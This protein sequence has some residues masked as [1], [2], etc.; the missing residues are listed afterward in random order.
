MNKNLLTLLFLFGFS[1]LLF[2]QDKSTFKR[3][4]SDEL[5]LEQLE[6]SIDYRRLFQ[7]NTAQWRL[8]SPPKAKR[9]NND[10]V[11][12]TVVFHDLLGGNTTPLSS[13]ENG[14]GYIVEGINHIY[15]GTAG[16][17]D[18]GIRFCLARINVAGAAVPPTRQLTASLTTLVPS[19]SIQKQQ[20]ANTGNSVNAFPSKKY[21][22]IYV[23]DS[24]ANV[25]GFASMPS[26]HGS[27]TDGIFIQRSFLRND[28]EFTDH[29]KVLA[30]ELGH[31]LG[32]FHTFGICDPETIGSLTQGG[33]NP[34]S[35]DNSDPLYNGDMVADTPPCML[36]IDNYTCNPSTWPD[37]CAPGD[38]PDLKNNYMD[39]G[40]QAC[41]DSFTQGQVDRMHFMIDSEFGVRNSLLETQAC[42][43][44][45]SFSGCTA[46]ITPS[47]NNLNLI[48]SADN[49]ITQITATTIPSYTF[50]VTFTGFGCTPP[51]LLLTWTLIEKSGGTII[52]SSTATNY[53]LPTTLPVGYYEIRVQAVQSDNPLCLKDIKYLFSVVPPSIATCPVVFPTTNGNWANAERTA[54]TGGWTRDNTAG[55]PYTFGNTSVIIPSTTASDAFG[56]NDYA[57]DTNFTGISGPANLDIMRVGHRLNPSEGQ[58]APPGNAQYVTL[59]FHPTPQNCKFKLHYIGYVELLQP[60]AIQYVNFNLHT[61]N[62]GAAFGI[63]S[64]YDYHSP[65]N[66]NPVGINRSGMDKDG[67]LGLNSQNIMANVSSF[68]GINDMVSAKHNSLPSHF[69]AFGSG[70]RM[71][72]WR[73]QILD[74][75]EF[76]NLDV[77]G[78]QTEITLTFFAHSNVAVNAQLSAYAY[79]AIECAGGG[80]PEPY[81]L[82]MANQ[83]ESC[84]GCARINF[85]HPKYFITNIQNG[86]TFGTSSINGM[87]RIN[88]YEFNPVSG[89]YDILAITQANVSN[90]NYGLTICLGPN[91][92]PFKDFRAEI[93]TLHGK[94]SDMVRVYNHFQDSYESCG[95][96]GEALSPTTVLV[97]CNTALPLLELTDSCTFSRYEWKRTGTTEVL[98]TEKDYQVKED[99]LWNSC[100]VTFTRT[101]FYSNPWCSIDLYDFSESFTV[102]NP[103]N[104][105]IG[106][107]ADANNICM[108]DIFTVTLQGIQFLQPDCIPSDLLQSLDQENSVTLQLYNP[109]TQ[110]PIGQ[111]ISFDFQGIPSSVGNGELIFVNED[112]DGLPIFTPSNNNNSFNIGLMTTY[113]MFGCTTKYST[114]HFTILAIKNSAVGGQITRQ[115]LC[116]PIH[117]ISNDPGI[118][119]GAY[120]WQFSTDGGSTW[121]DF[122]DPNLFQEEFSNAD[123]YF[124]NANH[125]G[126]DYPIHIRRLSQGTTECANPVPSNRVLVD[127]GTT[128]VATFSSLPSTLCSE[129]AFPQLPGIDDNGALGSWSPPAIVYNTSNYIFTPNSGSCT[130]TYIY[131]VT[132]AKPGDTTFSFP[133]SLCPSELPFK[134]PSHSLQGVEGVWTPSEVT[135]S[136]SY[137]FHPTEFI[138]CFPDAQLEITVIEGNQP[139]FDDLVLSYCIGQPLV[140]PPVSD[141]NIAGT[142]SP[143]G[144]NTST[145][146]NFPIIFTPNENGNCFT[147]HANLIVSSAAFVPT[148]FDFPTILCPNSTAPVLPS[149]SIEGVPGSW[150]PPTIS[151]TV[152]GSY[153]FTPSAEVCAI[154]TTIN[155]TV[156]ESCGITLNW[157]SEVTCETASSTGFRNEF[158]ADLEGGDCIKVCQG[159]AVTY[160]L[161]G[162]V[163]QIQSTTWAV[164]GGQVLN[165]NNLHITVRWNNLT[166]GALQGSINLVGGG[167]MKIDKCIEVIEVPQANFGLFPHFDSNVLSGCVRTPVYFENL[168]AG[169]GG[170]GTLYYQWDFGD[171]SFSSEFEPLHTYKNRGTY[172]VTLTIFNGCNCSSTIAKE[173]VIE[174]RPILI[175]CNSMACE[176]AVSTYSIPREFEDCRSLVWEVRGGT[177]ISGAHSTEISVLWN[178]MSRNTDGFGY[179]SVHSDGCF[180]SSGGTIKVPVIMHKGTIVGPSEFCPGDQFT[181]KLP[182]WPTTEFNWTVSGASATLFFN[183]QRNEII[184]QANESGTITLQCSYYNTVL[185]CGGSASKTLKVKQS[186]QLEGPEKV[187]QN[188]QTN[189]LILNEDFVQVVTPWRITGPSGFV[190]TGNSNNLSIIF[191]RAGIYTFTSSSSNFCNQNPI[192]IEVIDLPSQPTVIMGQVAEICPGIQLN[193]SSTAP[194]G[195]TTFWTVEGGTIIGSSAGNSVAVNFDPLATVPYRIHTWYE[196]EL[197]KSP[198]LTTEVTPINPI[199]SI[200]GNSSA[201]SSCSSEYSINDISAESYTWSIVPENAGSLLASQNGTLVTVLWNEGNQNSATVKVV[202]K[203]CGL[204]FERTKS[205]TI[206][207]APQATINPVQQG[208]SND[209]FSFNVGVDPSVVISGVTW[210]FGDG[211]QATGI[212]TSHIFQAATTGST[213]YI[214][215]ASIQIGGNCNTTILKTTTVTV[216]PAP[217]IDIT[218]SVIDL[219]E[220]WTTSTGGVMTISLQDGFAAT[221]TIKWYKVASPNDLLL[222]SGPSSFDATTSGVGAYY[223]MVT[224]SFGCTKTTPLVYLTSDCTFSADEPGTC[225]AEE[226]VDANIVVNCGNITASLNAQ[227]NPT[228]VGWSINAPSS[229]YTVIENNTNNYKVKNLPPGQYELNI[230]AVY[231]NDGIS[232]I[233]RK[234]KTFIVPYKPGLKFK[235]ECGPDGYQVTFLDHSVYIAQIAVTHR[236]FSIDGGPWQNAVQGTGGIYQLTVS[237]APGTHSAKM[238]ISHNG[239]SWCETTGTDILGFSL[240]QPPVADFTF[241]SPN[242]ANEAV[243]FTVTNPQ[244]GNTYLWDFG[245]LTYNTQQNPGKTFSGHGTR[246]VTLSVTNSHGC[247]SM[248]SKFVEVQEVSLL[249]NIIPDPAI[250]CAGNQKV[251]NYEPGLLQVMPASFEWHH[252]EPG[253]VP[254]AVT[255]VPTLTVSV[256]GRYF[257]YVT[258]ANGCRKYDNGST[259]VEFAPIPDPPYISG[260]PRVCSESPVILRVPPVAGLQY[261]WYRNGIAMGGWSTENVLEDYPGDGEFIYGVIARVSPT[262]GMFCESSLSTFQVTVDTIGPIEVVTTVNSCSPYEVTLNIAAPQAGVVYRWSNGTVGTQATMRHDG[263]VGVIASLNDCKSVWESDLPVDL[264]KL[265]WIFPQGC[266]DIC[267]RKSTVNLLG[268]Y[269][270][271]SSWQWIQDGAV[272]SSGTGEML[273]LAVSG[274][275]HT[276]EMALAT[277]H[278]S[279]SRGTAAFTQQKCGNCK[280]GVTVLDTYS[281]PVDGQCRFVLKLGLTNPESVPEWISVQVAG[282]EGYLV[283]ST[284]QAN[285][286]YSEYTVFFYPLNG[287]GGGNVTISFGYMDVKGELCLTEIA[288][289]FPSCAEARPPAGSN[290]LISEP[291][292]LWVAPNPAAEETTAYYSFADKGGEKYVEVADMLGRILISLQVVHPNGHL[293]LDFSRYAAGNYIIL[294]RQ[295]NTNVAQAKFILKKN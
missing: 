212:S 277:E 179:V 32:L 2:S 144:V 273:P 24:I 9:K 205:V 237:L 94:F 71:M 197:C 49:V 152:S 267:D 46:S 291:N 285:P 191:P 39:Y 171:G 69:S 137:V 293:P 181:F 246:V 194:S 136:G 26:N 115:G 161:S 67:T 238:R 244:P 106:F 248:I 65:L 170:N 176:G 48:I 123:I 55:F 114:P 104:Y 135:A 264:N 98:G 250:D 229:S 72:Q 62:A 28:S 234:K 141:N 162:S 254:F 153:I 1:L 84:S 165:Q 178:D 78:V 252:N 7:E 13:P 45:P 3:C 125:P 116:P 40:F 128:L 130:E 37:T 76:V 19:N 168:S 90:G 158:F 159:S 227:G 50:S 124:P 175:L 10:P 182:Q 231:I 167:Q 269:G 150:S 70:S 288:V 8:W 290:T 92:G 25:A 139:Q 211:T 22:N 268:P 202:A 266:Y 97:D 278:C 110:L 118:T 220:F 255:T 222:S 111:P 148:T 99:D 21:I 129:G 258:D 233:A 187:C 83:Q 57:T 30:H 219:C 204:N 113:K 225:Y 262:N 61:F 33:Y 44:C 58:F 60:T 163:S 117:V 134:L 85:T 101:T 143:A 20:L 149:E 270:L 217:I 281:S 201:F 208:C 203:R 294:L 140:L 63:L 245:D 59:K 17:I 180:C 105:Q 64:R 263:P 81:T 214:V 95:Q 224:N 121:T 131:E 177:I 226:E 287:F 198:E 284:L 223:A 154:P 27:M 5:H 120:S 100:A 279:F 142:W 295:D 221:S 260:S 74:F 173:I 112:E 41:Q 192:T 23:V 18:T 292:V 127:S 91:D 247:E 31:Y 230:N 274:A 35:C 196:N 210:D 80:L 240:P 15:D 164:T 265:L 272:A 275:S 89:Q 190:Q 166:G 66:P 102:Y 259:V 183:N 151:N 145:A 29:I 86:T 199:F 56:I 251:I 276:Y 42:E 16:G 107:T 53:S 73:E 239:A 249:G 193:Y 52:G 12:L 14:Y 77:P 126:I 195:S 68:Y 108:G 271:F 119:T 174:D 261:K 207:D 215:T 47:P 257:A 34:C 133:T 282:G 228:Q 200:S 138:G 4:G 184:V 43:A 36:I 235:S 96:F 236:Q 156:L 146:G 232:C 188:T 103:G 122:D 132:F 218:P 286:G 75:S 189:Y 160:S 93:E 185:H 147:Y 54:Y 289:D 87:G 216:A 169:G 172:R 243:L 109:Q 51:P 186:L 241:S 206:Q 256:P 213:T 155:M 38:G 253:P 79:F 280:V 82:E 11:V 209:A 6:N 283:A 242:C 88:A 157:H